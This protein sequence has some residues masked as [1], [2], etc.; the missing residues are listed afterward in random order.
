MQRT[1][2]DQHKHVVGAV[3][4]IADAGAIPDAAAPQDGNV[5]WLLAGSVPIFFLVVHCTL[6]AVRRLHALNAL[7]ASSEPSGYPLGTPTVE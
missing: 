3:W 1:A 4:G 5:L 2:K 6:V 7:V